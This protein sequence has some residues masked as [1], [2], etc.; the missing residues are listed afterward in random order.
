MG[1]MDARERE[2]AREGKRACCVLQIEM[3]GKG[4]KFGGNVAKFS[5]SNN[6]NEAEISP[7]SHQVRVVPEGSLLK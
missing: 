1:W 3:E 6:N 5:S 7:I 4:H 2:R